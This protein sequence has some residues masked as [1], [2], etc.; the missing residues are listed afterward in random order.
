[1]QYRRARTYS[2]VGWVS[3]RSTQPTDLRRYINSGEIQ[4]KYNESC[5][6]AGLGRKVEHISLRW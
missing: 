5:N 4:M 1:M 6:I 3:L 2:Q